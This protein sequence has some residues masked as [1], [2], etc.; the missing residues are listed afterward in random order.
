LLAFIF[1]RLLLLAILIL[2]QWF[3]ISRG[4]RLAARSQHRWLR[5]LGGVSLVI[6]VVVMALVLYDR[7]SRRFL[8]EQFSASVAPLLQL[9]IFTST[10]TFICEM[11]LRIVAWC[12]ARV[13]RLFVHK[14]HVVDTSRRSTFRL[15]IR[16]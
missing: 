6:A 7:I 13:R 1:R 5:W 8:P 9:W 14:E 10:F 11:L 4:W 15:W 16:N 2:P 12:G 3:W